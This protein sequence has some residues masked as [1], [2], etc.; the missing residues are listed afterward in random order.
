MCLNSMHPLSTVSLLVVLTV[1]TMSVASRL[2]R[3]CM[4]KNRIKHNR[5]SKAQI[6]VVLFTSI[7]AEKTNTQVSHNHIY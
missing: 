4:L 1:L 3:T 7:L 5:F 6:P 2:R